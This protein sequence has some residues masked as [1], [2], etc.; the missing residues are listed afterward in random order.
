MRHLL[1]IKSWINIACNFVIC[2][3][4]V[5][6]LAHHTY[7]HS[8]NAT[9]ANIHA[10]MKN[11]VNSVTILNINQVNTAINTTLYQALAMVS[12]LCSSEYQVPVW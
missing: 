4:N 7:T 1:Q 11:L 8:K 2:L 3:D 12:I 9:A 10:D 6:Y 5:F